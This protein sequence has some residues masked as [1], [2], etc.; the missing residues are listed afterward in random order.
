MG[1]T[2]CVSGEPTKI[3][4]KPL[5]LKNFVCSRN[6]LKQQFKAMQGGGEGGLAGL[7]GLPAPT[8]P[9]TPYYF[10]YTTGGYPGEVGGAGHHYPV[11]LS[12][13]T[14]ACLLRPESPLSPPGDP[15]TFSQQERASKRPISP[16]K[17]GVAARVHPYMLR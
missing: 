9:C 16:E 13:P 6:E 10:P 8:L 15:A 7:S 4:A 12:A 17:A 11:P 14:P 3:C 5:L 2:T 1:G